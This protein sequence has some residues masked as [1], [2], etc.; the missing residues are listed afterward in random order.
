MYSLN[1]R[2]PQIPLN[3]QDFQVAEVSPRSEPTRR[4]KSSCRTRGGRN[5]G[6]QPTSINPKGSQFNPPK[7]RWLMHVNAP[8]LLGK[9]PF[10]GRVVG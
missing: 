5:I 10:L 7:N 3:F 2:L 6:I 1:L 9:S 8:S 4:K